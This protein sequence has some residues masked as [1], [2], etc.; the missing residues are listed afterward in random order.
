MD[1]VMVTDWEKVEPDDFYLS[2]EWV[3]NF[4]V[5]AKELRQQ[6]KE[7]NLYHAYIVGATNYLI[8]GQMDASHIIID[9]DASEIISCEGEVIGNKH[10]EIQVYNNY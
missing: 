5:N 8:Y 4:S 7:G 1:Y 6:A 3:E 10:E 9:E 2:D